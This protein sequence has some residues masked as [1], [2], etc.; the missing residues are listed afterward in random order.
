MCIFTKN[1][2]LSLAILQKDSV[3]VMLDGY[4]ELYLSK[5]KHLK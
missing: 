3:C 4:S 5:Y 1:T 2:F